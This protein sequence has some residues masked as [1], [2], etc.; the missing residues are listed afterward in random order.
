MQCRYSITFAHFSR[1]PLTLLSDRIFSF[2]L[3]FSDLWWWVGLGVGV[4]FVVGWFFVLFCFLR[5]QFL[6]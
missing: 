1:K 5:S 4:C 2:G 6:L 3:L